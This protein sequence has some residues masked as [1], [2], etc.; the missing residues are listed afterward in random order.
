MSLSEK[1]RPSQLQPI[2]TSKA[3][4]FH[5]DPQTKRSWIPASCQAVNV[6][7]F[8]DPSLNIYR[9]IS[10]ED[11]KPVINSTVTPK[12]TFTKTSQKFGQWSDIRANTVYGLGFA[13]EPDLNKFIEKF[14]EIKEA[15]RT[16]SDHKGS[17]HHHHQPNGGNH[18]TDSGSIICPPSKSPTPHRSTT[19]SSST[20]ETMNEDILNTHHLILSVSGAGSGGGGGDTNEPNSLPIEHNEITSS[21]GTLT[22]SGTLSAHQRSQ[23][24]SGLQ[25]TKLLNESPN[26]HGTLGSTKDK[27]GSTIMLPQST[28][29]A[30]LRYENERLK[31]ALAQSSANAKKWEIELQTLKNNNSRL[32]GALQESTVNVEEWKRQLQSLKEE[33]GKMRMRILE[34]EA[35]HGDPEAIDE[36]G[37]EM[38]NLRTSAASL[39]STIKGKDKEIELLKKS[40]ESHV[41][42]NGASQKVEDKLNLLLA[43]NENLRSQLSQL[44]D[45]SDNNITK[46]SDKAKK[47][48]LDQVNLRL[49]QNIQELRTIHQEFTALLNAS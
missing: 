33:N 31:L 13:S 9:I 2:Y 49:G 35:S 39:E 20:G 15:S 22:K 12:M 3:H 24:L 1:S 4:V 16:S 32:T 23:S 5:I 34:L 44:Q 6:C 29:E 10:V 26:K 48:M 47:G 40:L 14:Q 41:S 25:V 21:S 8:H 38:N 19:V 36:L 18:H 28:T 43:E 46:F 11:N 42:V 30:Q 17:H 45:H 27:L 37:K 7:F